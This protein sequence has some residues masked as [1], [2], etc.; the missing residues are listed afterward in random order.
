MSQNLKLALDKFVVGQYIWWNAQ[1][2]FSAVWDVPGVIVEVDQGN[3]TF[4]VK[5]FDDMR[6]TKLSIYTND[7]KSEF[8]PSDIKEVQRFL[9]TEIS[10]LKRSLI[11]LDDKKY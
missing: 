7:E 9:H 5:T 2:H 1:R 6:E 8:R 11:D 4:T 3:N 10:K